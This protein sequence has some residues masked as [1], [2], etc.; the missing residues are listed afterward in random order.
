MLR[1]MD[2]GGVDENELSTGTVYDAEDPV[3]GRLGFIGND[4][5]FSPRTKLRRVDLPDIR[6][7]D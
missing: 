7:A 5:I 4:A 1:L 3:P 2:A 6:S